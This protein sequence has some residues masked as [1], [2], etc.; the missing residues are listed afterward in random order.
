MRE[1]TL[2]RHSFGVRNRS[3]EKYRESDGEAGDDKQKLMDLSPA[4][5]LLTSSALRDCV[6]IDRG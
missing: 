4:V 2:I 3:E 5:S 1:L 6:A